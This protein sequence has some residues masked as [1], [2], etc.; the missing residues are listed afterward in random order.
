MSTQQSHAAKLGLRQQLAHESITTSRSVQGLQQQIDRLKGVVGTLAP[1]SFIS[2]LQGQ[3]DRLKNTVGTTAPMVLISQ[4]QKQVDRLKSTIGTLAPMT[5]INQLQQQ[6]DRLKNTVGVLAPMGLL[7]S[8]DERV[9][10]LDRSISHAVESMQA[11]HIAMLRGTM[12]DALNLD[13][14][15]VLDSGDNPETI[16]AAVLNAAVADSHVTKFMVKLEN[17]SGDPH[18]WARFEPVITVADTVADTDVV[19][20]AE[21]EDDTAATPQ[22]ANGFLRMSIPWDTDAGATKT[23]VDGEE[24]TIDVQVN[25]GDSWF[26]KTVTKLT[27][28]YDV[29]A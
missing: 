12:S 26:G 20:V 25:A 15:L 6:V 9:T 17:A 4:L 22:F 27:K 10:R 8:L 29:I 5:F 11:M 3:V 1:I 2:R 21:W 19:P 7:S 18:Q 28:T 14:V 16:S 24:V 13:M 23:Y